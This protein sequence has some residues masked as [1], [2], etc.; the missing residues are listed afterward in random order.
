MVRETRAT[1]LVAF[2]AL[3]ES[4]VRT[5]TGHEDFAG[6]RVAISSGAPLRATTKE[7]FTRLTGVVVANYYG[8]AELGPLTY[9]ADPDAPESLGRPLPGATLEARGPDPM[10]AVIHARSESMA[11]RYLNAPGVLESRVDATGTYTTGDRGFLRDGHLVL[12]GRS[13]RMINVGGRKVDPVEV[14]EALDS[15]PG[16]EQAV[17]LEVRDRHGETVVGAVVV[18]RD[19]LASAELR[20]RAG[21]LLAAHKVPSL[22]RVVD[23]IPT[24]VIGKPA[25]T[26]LRALFPAPDAPGA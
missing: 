5:D 20:V 3:Y 22:I 12:T 23:A 24:T 16:V 6:V 15:V 18:L 13:N 10:D 14:T 2:P 17:V 8:V 25:F 11:T 26:E 4:F 7:R 1:R 9:S 21:E 19:G